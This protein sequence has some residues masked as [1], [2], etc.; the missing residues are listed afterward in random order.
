MT[1][2][3]L[4]QVRIRPLKSG[5][6]RSLSC[7]CNSLAIKKESGT[8]S[9]LQLRDS[10]YQSPVT[11]FS[12]SGTL[13]QRRRVTGASPLSKVI[14]SSWSRL[15]GSIWVFR[16]QV[17]QLM[18]SSKF[19]IWRSSNVLTRSKWAKTKSGQW[20]STST[21]KRSRTRLRTH[22]SSSNPR[23]RSSPVAATP[24]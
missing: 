10:W 12:R 21:S 19:G 24:L 5:P 18:V 11:S 2:S 6:P 16:L 22:P 17:H 14:R 13:L 9:S 7:S 23:F 20:T 8:C 4:R 1:S 15:I 3:L